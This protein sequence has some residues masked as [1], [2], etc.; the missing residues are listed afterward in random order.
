[1]EYNPKAYLGFQEARNLGLGFR[2]DYGIFSPACRRIDLADTMELFGRPRT[3]GDRMFVGWDEAVARF[4]AAGV[5]IGVLHQDN[6]PAAP[7]RGK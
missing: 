2:D 1:M 6:R 5:A 7:P 3:A 4:R